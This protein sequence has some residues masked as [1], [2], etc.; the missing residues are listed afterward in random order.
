MERD[1][2]NII[3]DIMGRIVIIFL[4]FIFLFNFFS[5]G[6]IGAGDLKLIMVVSLGYKRPLLFQIVTLIIAFIQSLIQMIR[7][8]NFQSRIQYLLNYIASI[9]RTG[10]I[11]LY[12]PRETVATEKKEYSIHLSISIFLAWIFVEGYLFLNAT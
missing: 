12:V 4:F 5:I 9:R 1:G 8:K 11:S 10:G 6:A 3:T 2:S 7:F